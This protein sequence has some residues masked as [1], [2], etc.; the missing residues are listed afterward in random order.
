[1]IRF[2]DNSFCLPR[3]QNLE[4]AP[5]PIR[6]LPTDDTEEGASEQG[7]NRGTAREPATRRWRTQSNWEQN[8]TGPAGQTAI[9]SPARLPS[10]RAE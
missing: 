1:M 4:A 5:G 6:N 2:V 8:G 3:G 7:S 9:V 10:D